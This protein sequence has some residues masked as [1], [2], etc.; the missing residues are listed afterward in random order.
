MLYIFGKVKYYYYE[1]ENVNF[2]KFDQLRPLRLAGDINVL[3][4]VMLFFRTCPEKLL[5]IYTQIRK[6]NMYIV[7]SPEH[8][9]IVKDSYVNGE[10]NIYDGFE[11]AL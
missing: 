8:S 10:P 2:N 3:T 6:W 7:N 4:T 1:H 5:D 9:I 11:P